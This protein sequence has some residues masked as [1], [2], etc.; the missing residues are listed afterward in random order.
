MRM[1]FSSKEYINPIIEKLGGSP[2]VDEP[3]DCWYWTSTEVKGQETEK[4]WL[5][6]LGSGAMQETPKIQSH[7]IRPIVTINK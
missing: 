7:K 2:I 6:S 4:S 1:L 5:Y 3:D